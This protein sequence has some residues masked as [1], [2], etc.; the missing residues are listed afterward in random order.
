MHNVSLFR[1]NCETCKT[2]LLALNQNEISKVKNELETANERIKNFEQEI[3]SLKQEHEA[4]LNRLQ[5]SLETKH[6]QEMDEVN[7]KHQEET[8]TMQSKMDGLQTEVDAVEQDDCRALAYSLFVTFCPSVSH[9][10]M[11]MRFAD[12]TAGGDSAYVSARV[13]AGENRPGTC[14]FQGERFGSRV[15]HGT[16]KWRRSAKRVHGKPGREQDCLP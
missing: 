15:E 8:R 1:T 12:Q 7:R 9:A 10:Q 13:I 2:L 4:E 16:P 5:E 11:N 6:K 14:G 3:V